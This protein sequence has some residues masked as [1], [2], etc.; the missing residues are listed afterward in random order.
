MQAENKLPRYAWPLRHTDFLSKSSTWHV[1]YARNDC[2]NKR[3]HHMWTADGNK[4]K[5][6]DDHDAADD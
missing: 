5:D 3:G 4:D 6:Q 2:V 1:N